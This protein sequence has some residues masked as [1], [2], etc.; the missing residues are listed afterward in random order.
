M[1][2]KRRAWS[3][4]GICLLLVRSVCF[5]IGCQG[6]SQN[7]SDTTEEAEDTSLQ[8][9]DTEAPTAGADQTT[10]N[11]EQ[12]EEPETEGT[13]S[14]DQERSEESR[15]MDMIVW[16][17]IDNGQST[18]SRPDN[19]WYYLYDETPGIITQNGH[20]RS[21]NPLLGT[22][23][24]ADPE[25]ARQH[26]YWLRAAGINAILCDLTNYDTL[27]A[28]EEGSDI[29]RYHS[30][31]L[32]NTR[33]LL[34]TAKA[35][36]AE[37]VSEV[38]K[39]FVS[40]R[41]FGDNRV[42]LGK[43]LDEIYVLYSEFPDEI[44]HLN[45][46][47]KP[48]I[49]VF[50][51]HVV[52]NDIVEKNT[53]PE[54]E[55]YDMRFT[56]GNFGP[57][58]ATDNTG[59]TAGIPYD[60]QTFLFWD[61]VQLP[62]KQGF[63]R[64]FYTIG[65]DGKP[66]MM[67]GWVS[68]YGGWS[69]DG[70][71]WDYLTQTYEGMTCFERTT[72]DVETVMPSAL[73][74]CRFN[75]ALCWK[76]QIQEGLGLYHSGHFEPCEEL[77]FTIFDNVTKRLYDLNNWIGKV[78]AAPTVVGVKNNHL[79]LDT[80]TYPLEYMLSATDSFTD[81][82]WT[83]ININDGIDYSAYAA[84]GE[85][86]IKTRNTFGESEAVKLTVQDTAEAIR[87]EAATLVDES[88]DNWTVAELTDHF[89]LDGNFTNDNGSLRGEW[90]EGRAIRYDNVDLR[91][92]SA[93]ITMKAKDRTS[94]HEE[95]YKSTI[96]LR[97][98]PAYSIGDLKIY[99]SDNGDGDPTS[100]LG[101]TG[102]GLYTYKNTLEVTVHVKED[103]RQFG[104][105]SLAYSFTLPNELSFDD[106]VKITVTDLGDRILVHAEGT[107]L[108][109]ILLSDVGEMSTNMWTGISYRHAEIRDASGATVLTADNCI[110]PLEGNFAVT[111]RANTFWI[112]HITVRQHAYEI[113]RGEY[114]LLEDELGL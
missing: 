97:L 36:K 10:H 33:V 58:F 62:N 47:D 18:N 31:L 83:Y 77:G 60:K 37:G 93:D 7:P 101:A 102:I 27:D 81:G 90:I 22:Y 50:I 6:G 64:S 63:Y 84:S 99:E 110:V 94:A 109:T 3:V 71:Q 40:V 72:V 107:L 1:K 56:N 5:L 51:D 61:P 20:F 34:E 55:R 9:T 67:T 29:H 85:V 49:D 95:A 45:G 52:M 105:R 30:G 76:E 17:D 89:A 113:L 43:V 48:F 108:C 38:P 86:W 26:L 13:P 96:A 80:A 11:P 98:D 75:Y 16:Y 91:F 19:G 69:S 66:E 70:S 44:Y 8:E 111:E 25:T 114:T 15:R 88:F 106:F 104:C 39:I 12:T 73:L 65:A 2:N 32:R 24:Q 14:A 53:Y 92:Y 82:E 78:P 23:D 100:Y 59:T 21:A 87:V 4:I 68:L 28:H 74:I 42:N 35:M 57:R 112:D 79:F 46:S 54:D 103:G 41:M